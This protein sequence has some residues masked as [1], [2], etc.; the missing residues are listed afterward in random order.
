MFHTVNERIVWRNSMKREPKSTKIS[1]HNKV[2]CLQHYNLARTAIIVPQV[3][4]I[5]QV[6]LQKFPIRGKAD[7]HISRFSWIFVT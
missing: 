7:K 2:M 1:S 3:F 5:E 4:K 6:K